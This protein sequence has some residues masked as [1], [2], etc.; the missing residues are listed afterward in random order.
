VTVAVL[1]IPHRPNWWRVWQGDRPASRPIWLPDSN[2]RWLP[3]A[4]AESWDGGTGGACNS[5][6]YDFHHVQIAHAPGGHWRRLSVAYP[7]RSTVTRIRRAGPAFL[8]AEG[9]GRP[10]LRGRRP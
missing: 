5:F 8:A 4:T 3:I 2:D 6:L 9:A 1:E 10:L 7:I